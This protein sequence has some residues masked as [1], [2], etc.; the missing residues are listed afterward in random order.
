M[1]D[2][3]SL[4]RNQSLIVTAGSGGVGKTTVAASIAL[5]AAMDGRRAAV[6]TID[7][8]RRLATALG[9]REF[10]GEARAIDP[11]LCASEGIELRAPLHALMLE[12]KSASDAMVRRFAPDDEARTR[13]FDNPY[14]KALSSSLAG[15]LEYMAIEQVRALARDGQFDLVVLDTPPAVHALD[16]LDAPE[17]LRNALDNRLIHWLYRSPDSG[18]VKTSTRLLGRGSRLIMRSLNKFTGGTF[19][20]DLAEFLGS[21]STIFPAFL[22]ASRTVH[23]LLR[24]PTT[25]FLLV[26]SPNPSVVREAKAFLGQLSRRG[27]PFGGFVCNRVHRPYPNP[28]K[29]PAALVAPMRRAVG[30]GPDAPDDA[31]LERVLASMLNGLH[32]HNRLA[33]RDLESVTQLSGVGAGPA[34]V[35]PLFPEDV[36]S[37]SGLARMAEHLVE[38]IDGALPEPH[39]P[40]GV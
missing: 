5:R 21:F 26:T 22:D 17:R 10:T 9:L 3:A 12:V 15:A 11:A 14:Y 39:A 24:E 2:L 29:S 18:P 8:A 37:L 25:S 31:A 19:F 16:F 33:T 23:E 34:A 36:H 32:A 38:P 40:R 27:F 30:G 1:S 35:V 6:L 13:I 4:I 7:P 28:A 20:N